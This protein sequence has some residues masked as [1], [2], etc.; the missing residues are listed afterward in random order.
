MSSIPW[1]LCHHDPDCWALERI[2]PPGK[3]EPLSWLITGDL[4]RHFYTNRYILKSNLKICRMFEGKVLDFQQEGD[5][6]AAFIYR[7][8]LGK[9]VRCNDNVK[10]FCYETYSHVVH[11]PKWLGN[12]PL[13]YP[14]SLFIL[15]LHSPPPPPSHLRKTL[16]TPASCVCCN[17]PLGYAVFG[18]CSSLRF[19]SETLQDSLVGVSLPPRNAHCFPKTVQMN[20]L[21]LLYWQM[22]LRLCLTSCVIHWYSRNFSGT[23]QKDGSYDDNI[24][25]WLR[26]RK[27][28]LG[29]QAF[30]VGTRSVFTKL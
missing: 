18:K 25:L 10:C 17:C 3:H 4:K 1:Y 30:S 11:N 7:L 28:T 6:Y 22:A 9:T 23:D 29:T 15:T 16:V 27:T 20:P 12:L 19:H 13:P 24:R 26:R 21:G 5:T 8:A 2:E 14:S